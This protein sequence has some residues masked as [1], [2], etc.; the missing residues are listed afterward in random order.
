VDLIASN[1]P[2]VFPPGTML[3]YEG[4]AMQVVGRIAEVTT[5]RD[6]REL[7]REFLLQPLGMSSAVYDVFGN[8]PAI[9]G[10]ARC[11][12]QDYLKFLRMILNN[13]VAD[14]GRIILNSWTVQTFF[15]NQTSGLP[16]R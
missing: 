16:E 5:G 7:A 1:T 10:G 8:N 14:D 2:V 11:S 9:A 15:T 13:G 4:D 12:A 6:W 3:D